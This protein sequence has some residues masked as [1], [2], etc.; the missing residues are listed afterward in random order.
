MSIKD[1]NSIDS[2]MSYASNLSEQACRSPLRAL[3]AC[4]KD[5][6]MPST[7]VADNAAEIEKLILAYE[8]KAK[9][10]PTAALDIY[11][12]RLGSRIADLLELK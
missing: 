3:E 6:P 1:I 10:C 7:W 12:L 11:K 9:H 8:E 2:F 4:P 5:Y